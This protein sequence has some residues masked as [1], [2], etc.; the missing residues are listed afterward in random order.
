[1]EEDITQV[2]Q[3]AEMAGKVY[4]ALEDADSQLFARPLSLFEQ[5]QAAVAELTTVI[6]NAAHKVEDRL[7]V[8]K[9]EADQKQ[10][11]L[12]NLRKNIKDYPRGLLQLQKRLSMELEQKMGKPVEVPILADV[13]EMK[14][15][16]WRGAVEGY[17]N[18]QKFY[19][20]VEPACYPEAQKLYDLI[21]EEFGQSSFGIVDIG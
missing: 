6:R 15:E 14:E 2:Q 12:A 5:A 17:L 18:T 19:L 11:A 7:S 9:A 1:M 13:L 4:A 3:A 20:L 10:A 16:A 8:Y 21:K